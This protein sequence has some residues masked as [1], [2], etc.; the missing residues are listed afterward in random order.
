LLESSTFLHTVHIV[1]RSRSMDP[2]TCLADLGDQLIVI[3]AS[4]W[5][6]Y[7]TLPTLMMHGQTQIK[8]IRNVTV[9]WQFTTKSI[10]SFALGLDRPW[11]QQQGHL[12]H[13][14]CTQQTMAQ[15][16]NHIILNYLL[17]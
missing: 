10:C 5:F 2:E 14:K 16:C 9:H 12:A 1:P 17:S 7:I 4:S 13:K 8:F 3:V 15:V 6:F 11:V